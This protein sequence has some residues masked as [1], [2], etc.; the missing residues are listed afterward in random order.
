MFEIGNCSENQHGRW[1]DKWSK[2]YSEMCSNASRPESQGVIWGLFEDDDIWRNI[3]AS[4]I[5]KYK[6][7]IGPSWTPI[8]LEMCKFTVGRSN[9]VARS[10][11]PR[12]VKASEEVKLEMGRVK[13]QS[14]PSTLR[15]LCDINNTKIAY[16]NAQSLHQP[17]W[18]WNMTSTC[19]MQM[20]CFVA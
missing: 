13:Q 5:D 19:Q 10:Y 8:V 7:K 3:L 12:K 16:I 14:C 6:P 9:E 17:K 18:I 11:D 2:L 15:N 20:S 4:S 1:L